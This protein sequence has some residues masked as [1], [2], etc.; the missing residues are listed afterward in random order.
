MATPGTMTKRKPANP[1][2][3]KKPRPTVRI[4]SRSTVAKRIRDYLDRNGIVR[5]RIAEACGWS[6]AQL[7]GKLNMIGDRSLSLEDAAKILRAANQDGPD[8][9]DVML[10][11]FGA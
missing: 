9:V 2:T 4:L 7:S 6:P 8:P 5:T 1:R 10:R 3:G 11:H